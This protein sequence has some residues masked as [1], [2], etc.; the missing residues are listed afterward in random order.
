MVTRGSLCDLIVQVDIKALWPYLFINGI[1]NYDDCN[2]LN[3]SQDIINPEIIKD[4]IL[5]I[6][7]RGPY[8][9]YDLLESLRQTFIFFLYSSWDEKNQN[10]KKTYIKPKMLVFLIM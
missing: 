1:F 7:T 3:W 9:N 6:R 10:L 4:I 5:I 8:A 2:V